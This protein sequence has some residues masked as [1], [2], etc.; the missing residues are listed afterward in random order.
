MLRLLIVFMAVLLISLHSASARTLY[1]SKTGDGSTG[2]SWETGFPTVTEAIESATA[3]DHIWVASGSYNEAISLKP[4]IE[5]YGGFSGNENE[6]QFD[7]RNWRTN[8]TILDATGLESTVVIAAENCTIDGFV[9]TNGVGIFPQSAGT[10]GIECFDADEIS[11][12]NCRIVNNMARV[13]IDGNSVLGGVGG[14]I[15]VYNTDLYISS[16]E[17][18]SNRADI[19]GGGIALLEGNHV[20]ENCL[21]DQNFGSGLVVESADSISVTHCTFGLFNTSYVFPSKGP[22]ISVTGTPFGS[23]KLTNSII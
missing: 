23:F 6:D 10:G 7:L 19:F 4:E 21:F 3:G 12:S 13:T 2:V 16:C 15:S 1:V 8:A 11:I 5:L 22:D 18:L 14:G 9:I 17:I 20:V